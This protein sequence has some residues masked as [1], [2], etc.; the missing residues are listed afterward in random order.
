MRSSLNRPDFFCEKAAR[1]NFVLWLSTQSDESPAADTFSLQKFIGLQQSQILRKEGL[2]EDAASGGYYTIVHLA[3]AL[4]L[5]EGESLPKTH[6]GIMSRSWSMRERLNINKMPVSKL[7]RL[8]SLME[9]GGYAP[10]SFIEEK[11]LDEMDKILKE[12]RPF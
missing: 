9:K 4:F 7:S 12:F 10:L 6:S 8:Q 1:P 5:R 11:G 2:S 3:D